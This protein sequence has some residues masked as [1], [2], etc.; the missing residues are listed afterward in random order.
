MTTPVTATPASPAQHLLQRTP[1]SPIPPRVLTSSRSVT[2]LKRTTSQRSPPLPS[3]HA[4]RADCQRTLQ[5]RALTTD[6]PLQLIHTQPHPPPSSSDCHPQQPAASLPTSAPSPTLPLPPPPAS[7]APPSPRAS[8][9]FSNQQP[10]LLL[11]NPPS[12]SQPH[13]PPPPTPRQLPIHPL[14][15]SS[16]APECP[17]PAPAT[18]GQPRST[19]QPALT[20]PHCCVRS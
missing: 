1:Y 6:P 10:P 3:P 19:R 16:S 15:S 14:R 2:P 13:V 18:T 4:K 9:P 5:L 7:A 8:S 17:H 12:S 11:Y 20:C